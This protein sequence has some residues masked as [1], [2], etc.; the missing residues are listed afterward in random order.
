M[1]WIVRVAIRD[2]RTG[3]AYAPMTWTSTARG[4]NRARSNALERAHRV[5]R[6]GIRAVHGD[7]AESDARLEASIISV[8][9]KIQASV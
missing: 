5:T 2:F 6:Q 8:T 7:Q 1:A 9:P 3:Q 4:E